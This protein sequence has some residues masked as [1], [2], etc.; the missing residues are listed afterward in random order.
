VGFG[1][2]IFAQIATRNI[3]Q[4]PAGRRISGMVVESLQQLSGRELSGTNL[5]KKHFGFSP[6]FIIFILFANGEAD[7]GHW[8]GW[9]R[10]Q[11]RPRL[12]IENPCFAALMPI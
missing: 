7:S 8:H 3:Q 1:L 6:L 4:I 10:S 2:I 5:S 12:K 11:D 9:L